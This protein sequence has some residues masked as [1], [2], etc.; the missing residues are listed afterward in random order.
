MKIYWCYDCDRQRVPRAADECASSGHF[1]V[2]MEKKA[3]I[4]RKKSCTEKYP[5]KVGDIAAGV[6]CQRQQGHEGWHQ[7]MIEKPRAVLQWEGS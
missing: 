7:S 3:E 1:V 4:D 6:V 2:D 5:E